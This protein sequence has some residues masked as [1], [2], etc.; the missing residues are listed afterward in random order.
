MN[1]AAVFFM[2]AGVGLA[3][4]LVTGIRSFRELERRRAAADARS[5]AASLRGFSQTAV[6]MLAERLEF[7]IYRTPARRARRALHAIDRTG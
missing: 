1:E 5:V 2:G 7:G 4:G 6:L 3:I